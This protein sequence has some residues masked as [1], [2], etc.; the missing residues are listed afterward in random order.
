MKKLR[1][2][3]GEKLTILYD[4]AK[5]IHAEACIN[6]LPGVFEKSRRPWIDADAGEAEAITQVIERCPTGALLYRRHDGG[7]EESA[8]TET[9]VEIVPNGPLYA[10]G[11]LRSTDS[12]DT[13][14]REVRVAYCRCGQSKN[15]PYCD[16]S[17]IAAAF[18]DP[19]DL[20]TTGA[21]ADPDPTP[22]EVTPLAD[23]PLMLRGNFK[24]AGPNAELCVHKAAL[25][26][27]G[28]SMNKPFCDG[29]HKG[30][31]FSTT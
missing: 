1:E 29:S 15:R 19:G 30:I 11:D 14:Q 6:G 28:E 27:C 12:T 23:G 25:C 17:H 4:V 16:N 18:T 20:G 24:L 21:T 10:H 5:C 3:E 13:D 9:I 2:Y 22:V 8:P 31:G 7:P 26:R